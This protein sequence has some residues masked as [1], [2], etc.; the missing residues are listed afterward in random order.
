[1]DCACIIYPLQSACGN[2]EDNES[3]CACADF[4][5]IAETGQPLPS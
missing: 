2:W 4:G 3:A 1:M 5:V